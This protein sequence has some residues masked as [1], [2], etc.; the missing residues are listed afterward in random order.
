M[1]TFELVTAGLSTF[2]NPYCIFLVIAGSILGIIFGAIPGL[3]ATMGM[4]IFLPMTF[5]MSD[6]NGIVFLIGIYVG[7]CYS[8]SLSAILVNIP[9]TPSAIA[10]GFDGYVMAQRGDAGRAIG[11][12]TVSSALGGLFG[13]FILIFA[14]PQLAKLALEFG[15]LHVSEVISSTLISTSRPSG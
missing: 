3:T 5:G 2:S 9:G 1:E 10:T 7:A 14:A 13:V 8:G 11:Y 12:S 6:L 4:A 15:I